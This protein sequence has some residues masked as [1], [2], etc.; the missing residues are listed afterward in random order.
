MLAAI[1]FTLILLFLA[2]CPATVHFRASMVGNGIGPLSPIDV[3]A[4]EPGGAAIVSIVRLVRLPDRPLEV[5]ACALSAL[6][7]VSRDA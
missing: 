1:E 2:A 7:A 4:A 5:S 3:E 6:C